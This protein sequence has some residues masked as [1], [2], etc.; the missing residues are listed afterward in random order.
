MN[1]DSVGRRIAVVVIIWA[2]V[3]TLLGLWLVR[4]LR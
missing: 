4:V 1:L 2:G 3:E